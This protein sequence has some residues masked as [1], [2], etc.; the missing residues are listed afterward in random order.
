MSRLG[1]NQLVEDLFALL[2]EDPS[3]EGVRQVI[4]SWLQ[5]TSSALPSGWIDPLPTNHEPSGEHGSTTSSS[6]YVRWFPG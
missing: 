1:G 6:I 5:Q 4:I 2:D 3:I